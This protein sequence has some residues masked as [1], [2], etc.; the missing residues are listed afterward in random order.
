MEH[1][2]SSAD[3]WEVAKLVSLEPL[4]SN[5]DLTQEMEDNN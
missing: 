2:H 3:V 1:Y 4:F 5:L